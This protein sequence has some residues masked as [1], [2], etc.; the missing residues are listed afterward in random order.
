MS[1]KPRFTTIWCGSLLAC[2]LLLPAGFETAVGQVRRVGP[3]PA[4]EQTPGGTYRRM[5]KQYERKIFGYENPLPQTPR[6]VFEGGKQLRTPPNLQPF[7]PPTDR[8]EISPLE[9]SPS[10]KEKDLRTPS[11][12]MD[13][14]IIP[15]ADSD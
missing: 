12:G 15:K 3:S 9:I 13:N 8:L 5:E 6:D 14:P 10:Y 2:F 4:K 7:Q 11:Q 1:K